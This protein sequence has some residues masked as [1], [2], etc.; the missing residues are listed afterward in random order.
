M[1]QAYHD[2]LTGLP[3]RALFQHRLRDRAINGA[4]PLSAVLFIDLDG[5][6]AANDTYGHAV[7]DDLLVTVGHRLKEAVRVTDTLARFGG[8]EFTVLL[9]R[10][11]SPAEAEAIADR[12]LALLEEPMVVGGVKLYVSASVGV[13][14]G[15]PAVPGETL[16]RQADAAM[17]RAKSAGKGRYEVAHAA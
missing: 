16:L 6:K 11:V 5:F 4:P 3:N 10:I 1:R 9:D 13:A 2:T 14:V 8:D 7:G 15:G 12:V 17:Y